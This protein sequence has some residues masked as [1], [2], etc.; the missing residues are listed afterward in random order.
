LINKLGHILTKIRF[1]EVNTVF[2]I[3][4]LH[5]FLRVSQNIYKLRTVF[6]KVVSNFSGRN[7][8]LIFHYRLVSTN[9]ENVPM[10]FGT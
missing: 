3:T 10:K 5:N 8:V 4:I 9:L 6:A 7:V 2:H 1:Y